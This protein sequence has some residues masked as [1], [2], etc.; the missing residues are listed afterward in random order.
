MATV[1]GISRGGKLI[2]PQSG[3]HL[4]TGDLAYVVCQREHVRRTLALFGHEEQEAGSIVIVGGG[5]IGLYVARTIEQH[6]PKTRLKIVEANRDR[7]LQIAD[8]L[9]STVVLNGSGLDQ[10]LMQRAD[11]ADADLVIC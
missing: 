9:R 8:E 11:I 7:A 10:K 1:T 6:Q 2:I 3:D 5:N 4:L